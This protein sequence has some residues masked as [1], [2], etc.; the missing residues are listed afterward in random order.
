MHGSGDVARGE[1]DNMEVEAI[2]SNFARKS[3]NNN[4]R[5]AQRQ[6]LQQWHQILVKNELD[7]IS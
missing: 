7:G 2:R 1:Y 3:H 6:C 4:S 5:I